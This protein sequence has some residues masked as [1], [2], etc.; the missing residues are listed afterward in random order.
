MPKIARK[1]ADQKRAEATVEGFRRDLGP[2]VVAA[3][4]TRMPMVFT[5][6]K[7]PGHLI[8]FVNDSFLALTGYAREEVLGQRLD[9]LSARS[10]GPG[11]PSQVEDAFAAGAEDDMESHYRRKNGEVFRAAL[12]FS[13]VRDEAGDVVQNFISL[14][15]LSKH[16]R[17]EERLRFLL[18]ELNHRTQNT[19]ASVQSIVL[20][21]L[22]GHADPSLID[23]LERRILALSKAHGLLGRDNWD[24]VLLRDVL[25]EIMRPIDWN[26]HSAPRIS[27]ESPNVRLSPKAVL[28]L[29]VVLHEMATNATSH[30]ALSNGSD[31]RVDVD[32]G[33][34]PTPNGQRMRL[35]WRES[36]GPL[37]KP[38]TEQGFGSRLLQGPLAQELQG[39]VM[40]DFAPAGMVCTIV[41]P[42]SKEAAHDA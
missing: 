22:R 34:V 39:E 15:D 31:G 33:M 2:F 6:A 3:E 32:W 23:T 14:V 1:S 12:F 29:A 9:F 7:A 21:T 16:E 40:L 30:G 41:M 4:T 10:G 28:S 36:G 17:E 19:L 13:A 27:P 20:R 35:Q 18:D 25:D 38:P 5:D 37:V 11:A 8:I 42:V 24:A 26:G